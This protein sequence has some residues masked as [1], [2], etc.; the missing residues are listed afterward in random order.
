M[1]SALANSFKIP[2]LKRRL[3]ITAALIAVY[4]VGCYVPTPGIDVCMNHETLS[5][6]V[7]CTLRSIANFL[8]KPNRDP[9][10]DK[11][12]VGCLEGFT[13]LPDD[14]IL[15]IIRWMI[16]QN[17][18]VEAAEEEAEKVQKQNRKKNRKEQVNGKEN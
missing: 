9:S 11:R 1:L 8:A 17:V 10:T 12:L 2:D 14:V 16:E 4:R 3:L 13:K 5:E 15:T 18:F 7:A 6:C